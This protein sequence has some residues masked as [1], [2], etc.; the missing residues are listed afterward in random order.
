MTS[1]FSLTAI[2]V[3]IGKSSPF[4]ALDDSG[5][6]IYPDGWNV[7]IIKQKFDDKVWKERLV[8][9][10]SQF[11]GNWAL[12]VSLNPVMDGT[13]MVPDIC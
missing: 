10:M 2:M 13:L 12:N 6:W 4:M 3:L 9:L 1:L 8:T 5:E 11:E 7:L